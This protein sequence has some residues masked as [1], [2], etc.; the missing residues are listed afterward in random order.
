MTIVDRALAILQKFLSSL[1]LKSFLQEIRLIVEQYRNLSPEEIE[2]KV[3]EYIKNEQPFGEEIA[4][5]AKYA[6]GEVSVSQE[7]K[8]QVRNLIAEGAFGEAGPDC[9]AVLNY[10]ATE[11][12]TDTVETQTETPLAQ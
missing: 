3:L 1:T 10:S 7:T 2:V 11:P 8:Q 9:E 5:G 6:L 12:T 4:E